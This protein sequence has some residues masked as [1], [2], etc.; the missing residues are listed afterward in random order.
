[1]ILSLLTVFLFTSCK[2][3]PSSKTSTLVIAVDQ[4]NVDDLLCQQEPR[5]S[6]IFEE[7]CAQA[8]RFSH[9]YT[10]SNL[11]LPAL[12]SVMTAQYPKIHGL[13]NNSDNLKPHFETVAE[14]AFDKGLDTF[15][16]SGG[17]PLLRKSGLQQGFDLFE[18]SIYPNLNQI[19][20][21]F[22]ESIQIFFRR[23]NETQNKNFFSIIYVSDLNY[24]E[25]ATKNMFGELR[26]ASYEGQ[27]EEFK[28]NL[29][30]LLFRIKERELWDKTNI[31]IV[32]LQGRSKFSKNLNNLT[33]EITQVAAFI[34]P[35]ANQSIK[36]DADQDFSLVDIGATLFEMIGEKTELHEESNFNSISIFSI[37]EMSTD[38]WIISESAWQNWHFNQ[39]VLWALKKKSITCYNESELVCFDSLLDKEKNI[40]LSKKEISHK[41]I[42]EYLTPLLDIQ[43]SEINYLKKP[44]LFSFDHK[45][46]KCFEIIEKGQFETSQIKNCNDPLVTDL[47]QWVISEENPEVELN[48]KEL[49][50]KKFFRSYYYEMIDR[51]ISSLQNKYNWIWDI[52]PKIMTKTTLLDEIWNI[53]KMEKYKIQSQRALAQYRGEDK[54]I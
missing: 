2:K 22:E 6:P 5:P 25:A 18:D 8:V 54:E 35:T 52:N 13:R 34:K 4:L 26:P 47:I 30:Q 9:V 41:A 50:K 17:A 53:P 32:G 40:P 10:T 16:I 7:F 33:P 43:Y 36:V 39:N 21:S 20:R 12:A 15:L 37:P 3:N 28:E 1:M 14:K 19:H 49:A 24:L 29:D 31:V 42:V 38:R 23:L 27:L 44:T 48:K 45:T 46:N 51:K 11:S